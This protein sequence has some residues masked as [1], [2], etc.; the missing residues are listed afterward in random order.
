M[1][2][3]GGLWGDGDVVPGCCPIARMSEYLRR[4]YEYHIYPWLS[5]D[6]VMTWSHDLAWRPFCL[7]FPDRT[8]QPGRSFER[9]FFFSFRGWQFV[10]LR[11]NLLFD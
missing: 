8:T 7:D 6:G 2:W 5:L 4:W 10:I 1:L 3:R 9:G 11:P